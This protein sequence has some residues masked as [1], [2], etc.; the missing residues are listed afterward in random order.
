M[1]LVLY[2]LLDRLCFPELLAFC[3]FRPA[4]PRVVE[5]SGFDSGLTRLG[6][7]GGLGSLLVGGVA[8]G[9]VEPCGF[10]V[11]SQD[12]LLSGNL[13]ASEGVGAQAVRLT[14]VS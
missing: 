2:R 9:Y 8:G 1:E 6:F 10:V 5:A 7:F 3:G 14:A 13:A 4:P 11:A 12:E